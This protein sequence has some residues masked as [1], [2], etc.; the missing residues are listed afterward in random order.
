[1]API[2]D[3]VVIGIVLGLVF[4]AMCYYLYSRM[5]QLERKVGLME[6]I[7][8][9]LKVTTEQ[10]LLSATELPDDTDQSNSNEEESDQLNFNQ[11]YYTSMN[12]SGQVEDVV[13]PLNEFESSNE[14]RDVMVEQ[15]SRV[16]TPTS[17][18]Q[19]EKN[20]ATNDEPKVSSGGTTLTVNY[21][22][23]TY[24]EL[25]ALG[26]QTGVTGIRNMSKAQLIDAIRRRDGSGVAATVS[27][28]QTELSSWTNT[29]SFTD[30]TQD[31]NSSA[32][33]YASPLSATQL[34]TLAETEDV[35]ASFVE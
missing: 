19:V 28:Q 24:K 13:S 33:D 26:K 31:A 11:Q 2:S 10:T 29:V 30:S 5:T 1:M 4:G 27:S 7:L 12:E 34:D 25:S 14:S 35:D 6:N 32:Q 22:A 21:E 17:S 20:D 8:L 3:A 23:M 15:A 18:V 9:D 16:R